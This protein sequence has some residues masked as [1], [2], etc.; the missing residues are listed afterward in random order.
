MDYVEMLSRADKYAN[1]EEAMASKREPT[2]LR[3]DKR[4]KRRRDEPTEQDRPIRPRGPFQ[5]QFEEY[6]LLVVPQSQ[7]LMEVKDLGHFSEPPKIQTPIDQRNKR[8]YYRF[9]RDYGHNI[10]KCQTLKDEIEML[11]CR[12]HLSRYVAQKEDQPK[13]VEEKA[14]EQP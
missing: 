12:G 10:D 1:V 5:P 13:P 2:T 6:T 9:H 3:P 14:V 11:I 7:I 8:K 4:A